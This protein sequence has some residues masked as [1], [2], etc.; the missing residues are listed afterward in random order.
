MRE[1]SYYVNVAKKLGF[2]KTMSLGLTRVLNASY[3]ATIDIEIMSMCNLKCRHCRV[4]YYGNVIQD[5]EPAFMGL[6]RF[7]AILDRIAPLVKKA[8]FFQFSTVEPLFHKDLFNMMDAVA[9]YNKDI[10]FPLLSNGMLLTETNIRNLMGRNVPS[11]SIS[12]D[13]CKKET[14]ESFKTNTDFDRVVGNIRLL[15]KLGHAGI[16]IRVVFVATNHNIHELVEYVDFCAALGVD[17]ILVNGFQSFLPEN[18]HRYLYSE[19]GNPGAQEIFQRAYER[20]KRRNIGIEFPSL[21]ARPAGCGSFST[22]TINESGDVS[23]CILL[24][25]KTPF[26]LF[27]RSAT[28]TTVI[29]GNVFRDDPRSV[30][31]SREA[32]QFRAM[33]KKRVIP[34]ACTL[35]PDAYGVICSNRRSKL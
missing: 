25:R 35:C 24:A 4:T 20:A 9:L 13:G 16:E 30:W 21:I 3:P 10:E 22:M 19:Q 7:Q 12:L 17:R 31:T 5:V 28:S 2:K 33:L 15:R 11:I 34:A 26:E 23:P 14:V 1:I 27:Q 6:D 8:Q 29:W 18:A 32:V